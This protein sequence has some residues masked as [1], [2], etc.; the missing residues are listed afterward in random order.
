MCI[1]KYYIYIYNIYIYICKY[2]ITYIYTHMQLCHSNIKNVPVLH[3]I[4]RMASF[5]FSSVP[6]NPAPPFSGK[7]SLKP[8]A[9]ADCPWNPF[10][11]FYL[12]SL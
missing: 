10:L 5:F 11:M 3:E 9:P 1:Y 12:C 2:T 7:L 6:W 4:L 8:L